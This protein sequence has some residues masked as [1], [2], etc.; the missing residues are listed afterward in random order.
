[1]RRA[2]R[3]GAVGVQLLDHRVTRATKYCQVRNR[4]GDLAQRQSTA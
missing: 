1:M 3:S 2:V 4:L